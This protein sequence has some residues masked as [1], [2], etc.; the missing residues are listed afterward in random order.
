[1]GRYGALVSGILLVGLVGAI[2]AGYASDGEIGRG[3]WDW[4]FIAATLALSALAVALLGEP[5]RRGAPARSMYVASVL[6]GLATVALIWLA[7]DSK[8][9]GL[10]LLVAGGVVA[11]L[12]LSL[13]GRDEEGNVKQAT[14]E[15]ELRNT[16]LGD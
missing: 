7:T 1:M 10:A 11:W 8:R 2:L 4:L 14:A 3:S 5:V 15:E 9:A 13:T 6:A 16:T 12:I